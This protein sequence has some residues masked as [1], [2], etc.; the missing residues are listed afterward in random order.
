MS[1]MATQLHTAR[2]RKPQLKNCLLLHGFCVEYHR[3][4]IVKTV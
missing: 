3:L 4:N 1:V 2:K